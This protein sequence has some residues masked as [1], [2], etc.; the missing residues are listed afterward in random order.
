MSS[1]VPSVGVGVEVGGTSVG[2]GVAV[3]GTGA[4]VVV[5]DWT[6]TVAAATV[7]VTVAVEVGIGCGVGTVVGI[8][9]GVGTVVGIGCGVGTVIGD[10][11][12][13]GSGVDVGS[14]AFGWTGGGVGT[15]TGSGRAGLPKQ[16]VL[17]TAATSNAAIRMS[18]STPRFPT[19]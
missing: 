15:G 10:S 18:T 4:G 12:G 1:D 11:V 13:V 17:R 8:G 6:G 16:A 7:G 5:L 3:G 2:D 9:C 14:S 19:E